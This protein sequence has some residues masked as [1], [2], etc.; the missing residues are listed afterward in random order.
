MEREV[1]VLIYFRGDELAWESAD[2]IV[3]GKLIIENKA[4]EKLPPGANSQLY[5]YLCASMYE[6]GL[7]LHYGRQPRHYR[8]I[9]ENRFKTHYINAM[10]RRQAGEE[11]TEL[12][13]PHPHQ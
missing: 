13:P 2:M 7:V 11:S 6:V 5:S 1:R 8:A 3:D 9:F 12:F 4:G 10:S